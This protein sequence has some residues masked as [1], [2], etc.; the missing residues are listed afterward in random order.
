LKIDQLR[1]RQ[2]VGLGCEVIYQKATEDM[3]P[4]R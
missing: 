1:L 3:A 2:E 4:T